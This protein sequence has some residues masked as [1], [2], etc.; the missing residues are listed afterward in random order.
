[1][2]QQYGL[3]PEDRVNLTPPAP[4]PPTGGDAAQQATGTTNRNT[5]STGT[6]TESNQHNKHN[7]YLDLI[8]ACYETLKASAD[9]LPAESDDQ[10][11]PR[12][13]SRGRGRDESD[14]SEADQDQ[15]A[16]LP[17]ATLVTALALGSGAEPEGSAVPLEALN[18]ALIEAEKKEDIHM[19]DQFPYWSEH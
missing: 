19:K 3:D 13:L 12:G 1:M 5:T 4:S 8:Q 11:T 16:D 17:V 6:A 14:P 10:Q 7:K 2:Q 15:D 18:E 9:S